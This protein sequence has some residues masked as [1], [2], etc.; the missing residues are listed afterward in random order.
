MVQVPVGSKLP[1]A[2]VH[3]L[4]AFDT[5]KQRFED[6]GSRTKNWTA[7]YLTQ[8]GT[9]KWQHGAYSL[10]FEGATAKSVK[11]NPTSTTVDLPAHA[12]ITRAYELENN[13]DDYQAA[14]A[15][16]GTHHTLHNFF[17]EGQGPHSLQQWT[18]KHNPLL[19]I[20]RVVAAEVEAQKAKTALN[21]SISFEATVKEASSSKKKA[22]AA[23]ARQALVVRQDQLKK[24][25]RVA[26][27]T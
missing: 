23:K 1:A 2:L 11:H 6:C 4:V 9:I 24:Q 12:V 3:K 16:Q 13:F 26:F 8:T 21:Q 18:S 5:F 10:H 17:A 22:A 15:L 20:S 7:D 14:A 19:E 27:S 25:R